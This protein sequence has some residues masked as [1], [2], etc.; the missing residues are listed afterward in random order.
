MTLS[1]QFYSFFLTV[2][3]GFVIGVIFDLYRVVLGLLH[4]RKVATNLGDFF[5][6]VFITIVVFVLLM[7]GNWG[8]VRLYVFL[9]L[10]LGLIA[11]LKLLSKYIILSIVWCINIIGKCI[12]WVK[13]G[14]NMIVKC[15][16]YPCRFIYRLLLIPVKFLKLGQQKTKRTIRATGTGTKKW[17]IKLKQRF[18]RIFR[19]KKN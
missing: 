10:F 17:V 3:I 4:P 14:V 9:G 19:K 8:E 2:C 11:Y 16:S 6:W 12:F 1:M 18:K 7:F 13:K 15:V 5:F